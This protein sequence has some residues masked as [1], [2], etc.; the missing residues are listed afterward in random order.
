MC[1]RAITVVAVVDETA[2]T[3]REEG[4]ALL[5]EH[6]VVAVTWLADGQVNRDLVTGISEGF[7]YSVCRLPDFNSTLVTSE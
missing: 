7:P 1:A 6:A 2:V 5:H 3:L 4:V